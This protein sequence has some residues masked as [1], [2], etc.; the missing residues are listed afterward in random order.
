MFRYVFLCVWTGP[1][2]VFFVKPSL[3]VPRIYM[4]SGPLKNNSL[5]RVASEVN[6]VF[7]KV[8]FVVYQKES[9]EQKKACILIGY[10][11]EGSVGIAS[12]RCRVAA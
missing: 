12:L 4:V 7:R 1:A 6:V 9:H 3:T 11:C 10:R 2:C 5:L 8:R